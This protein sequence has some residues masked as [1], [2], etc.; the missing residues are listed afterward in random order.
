MKQNKLKIQRIKRNSKDNKEG[1][2]LNDIIAAILYEFPQYKISDVLD[3]NLFTLYYLFKYVGKIANYEVNKIAFGNGLVKKG[4][5][6]K[7]FID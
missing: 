1:T 2:G 4:Q 6:I 3:M 7:Y 5:K